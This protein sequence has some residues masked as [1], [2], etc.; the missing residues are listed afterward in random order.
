VEKGFFRDL[1]GKPIEGL[2]SMEDSKPHSYIQPRDDLLDSILFTND[3]DGTGLLKKEIGKF[4][5]LF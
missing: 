2:A 4:A 3:H 1:I 5:T